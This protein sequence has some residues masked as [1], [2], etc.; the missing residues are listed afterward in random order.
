MTSLAAQTSL[1]ALAAAPGLTVV[2]F[3]GSLDA[4]TA[5][6]FAEVLRG[7]LRA[8]RVQLLL[9]LSLL[10]HASSVG[11]R[12]LLGLLQEARRLGG[13]LRLAG[14]RPAVAQVLRLAGFPSILQVFPDQASA[15]TSWQQGGQ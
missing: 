7:Q 12:V 2:G 14:A 1:A 8:G 13:D 4:H 5:G 11:L 10:E 9:E 6:T 15:V 3:E